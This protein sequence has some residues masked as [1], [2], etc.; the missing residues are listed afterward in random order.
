MPEINFETVPIFQL[1]GAA[2]AIAFFV[3]G[4]FK[5]RNYREKMVEPATQAA[6]AE[7][8]GVQ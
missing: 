7:A 4:V 8:G 5:Y 1:C 2:L 3:D 6:A